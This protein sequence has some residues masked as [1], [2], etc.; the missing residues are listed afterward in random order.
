MKTTTEILEI[1]RDFKAHYAEKYGIIT[2]GLFGSVARGEHD[3]KSDID[4]C[5]KLR[6]PNYFTMQDIKDE[7]E[8][9]FSTKVDV[10]SLGSMMR[11]FFRKSLEKDAIYI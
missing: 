5:V 4:I 3:E 1:L 6:E 10:I 2:L 11:N 9:R 8:D 7:L